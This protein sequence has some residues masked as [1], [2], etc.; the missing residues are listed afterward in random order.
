MKE[1]ELS[2]EKL[3]QA[4]SQLMTE[5]SEMKNLLLEAVKKTVETK[6]KKPIGI[7]EACDLVNL[8]KPTVYALCQNRTIPCYR[9]TGGKLQFFEDELIE[10]VKT[11]RRKTQY[12]IRNEAKEYTSNKKK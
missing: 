1:N 6:K 7:N 3:P 5:V 11:G 9:T 4:F 8:A 10:W 12:E 2:L